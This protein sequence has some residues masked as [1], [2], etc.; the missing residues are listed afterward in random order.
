MTLKEQLFSRKTVME[1]AERIQRVYPDFPKDA[2]VRDCVKAFGPLELKERMH[3]VAGMLEQHMTSDFES[4][5][6]IF[7]EVLKNIEE[8]MFVY[9]AIQRYIERNGN[10]DVYVDLALRKLGEFTEA[11]SAEFAIRPFF[12]NYPDKTLAIVQEWASSD[13][14]HIRRLASEGSRPG[15]PWAQHINIDYKDGAKCLDKLYYDDMRYVTRSVANHLND[16]AK[17]DPMYVID[18]LKRW[19]SSN[20]QEAKE[21]DYIIHHSLRT[22]IKQGHPL[23]LEMIGYGSTPKIEI[24]PIELDPTRLVIGETLAFTIQLEAKET[25][26]LLLDYIITYP[27]KHGRTTEKVYKWMTIKAVKGKSYTLSGKRPFKHLST[28]TMRPG[29][30]QIAIQINGTKLQEITFELYE[31]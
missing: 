8:S 11:F 9:G 19:I 25:V 4:N 2:F 27:T 15:L 21:M 28:R 29:T 1:L 12:N 10:N 5:L 18:T 7:T 17:I 14:Y 24:S 13:N 23:A 31:E 6:T 30:H 20:K 22:L 26:D 3:H 16:I